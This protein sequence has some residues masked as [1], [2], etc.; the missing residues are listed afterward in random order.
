MPTVTRDDTATATI[1]IRMREPLRANI[2]RA[3]AQNRRS[4]NLEMIERLQRSFSEE[5]KDAFFGGPGL[6]EIAYGMA[7]AFGSHGT[8]YAAAN[9]NRHDPAE[10]LTD[11]STYNEA[12]IGVIEMLWAMHPGHPSPDDFRLVLDSASRRLVNSWLTDSVN[13]KESQG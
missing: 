5:D 4:M 1:K 13:K 12:M 8:A 9:G 3:A 10:W 2:E 7:S 11:E 6:R